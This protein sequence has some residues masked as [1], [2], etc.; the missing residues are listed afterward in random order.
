MEVDG[1]NVSSS[2]VP[3]KTIEG[4]KKTLDNIVEL[5]SNFDEFM[6]LVSD[7][8]VLAQLSPLDRAQSLL[9][10]SKL[11][12]IL[13]SVKL[14]CC[15]VYPDHHPIK[16]EID[17]LDRYQEKLE[18]FVELSKAPLRPSTTL[19]QRAATRFIEH[20]LPD[21]TSEQRKSL[22]AISNGEEG[23]MKYSER[24][25]QKKRKYQSSDT[26]SVREAAREFL[27]KAARELLGENNGGVKGP[28]APVQ[29]VDTNKDEDAV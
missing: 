2:V 12:S 27:E 13:L 3:K 20:S 21:L 16:G 8:N 29:P 9:N 15:G 1:I 17:R 23:G 14:R 7:P 10:L 26:K 4:V 18:R 5:E 22:R 24:N 11:T 19:N 25:I 28:L 6:S